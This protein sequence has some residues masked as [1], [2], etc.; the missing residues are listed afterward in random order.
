MTVKA[1]KEHSKRDSIAASRERSIKHLTKTA[2]R[3]Y[4]VLDDFGA[5]S[6]DVIERLIPFLEPI[7]AARA[8][9]R[10]N[11]TEIAADVRAA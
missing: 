10:L 6:T 1:V 3:V 9:Q 7:L 11:T 2:A 8:G 5:G 4:A